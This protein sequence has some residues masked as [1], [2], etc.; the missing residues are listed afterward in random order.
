MFFTAVYDI[1]KQIPP[2]KVA[3]YGQ[4]AAM[5]GNPRMARQVGWALH[6]NPDE[7]NIPCHRVVNRF[8]GCSSA[9]A[10]GGIDIQRELLEAEGVGFTLEGNVDLDEHLWIPPPVG[11]AIMPSEV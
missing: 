11:A 7:S 4:I 8:G 6:G 9:F 2:G 5:A 3:T 1:V 10:F